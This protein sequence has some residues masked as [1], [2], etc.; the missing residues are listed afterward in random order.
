MVWCGE[1]KGRTV[2]SVVPC[3]SLPATECILVVSRASLSVSGG[4]I[5]GRRLAIMLFPDPG[6]PTSKMLCPPAQAT[7]KARLTFS[8]PFTSAKS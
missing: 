8:W 1:R 6:L 2:I 5:D 7:S 4:R 3:L